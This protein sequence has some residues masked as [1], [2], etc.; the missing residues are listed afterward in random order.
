MGRPSKLTQAQWDDIE[1]RLLSGETARALGREYEVSEAAIRKKFGAHQKV[2]AQSSQVRTVAEKL[3]EANTALAALPPAQRPVA[4]NLA[5]KLQNISTSLA[6]AA[7]NG[8]ATAHRLSALANTEVAKIDDAKPLDSVESLKGVAVLT[9]LANESASIAINLLAANKDRMKEAEEK[10]AK[11]SV[12]AGLGH[13][14]G[15]PG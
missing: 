6:S 11:R 7:E 15:Q 2:S 1:R 8:A 12:P 4:I 13:F 9:K 3:A 10:A 14:Y 5:E